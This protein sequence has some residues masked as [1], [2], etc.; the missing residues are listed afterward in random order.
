MENN[1]VKV[2]LSVIALL[3]VGVVAAVILRGE[4]V[5]EGP[6]KYDEFAQCLKDKG[7]VFY[8]AWWCPHCAD[9]KKLF[10]SSQKLLPYVECYNYPDT[11]N[12]LPICVDKK[13]EGYPTWDLADGTRLPNE[14]GAGVTL[15]TLAARTSCVLP[16]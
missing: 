13:I 9:Q 11:K 1:Q 2:F 10:G 12:P 8:G 6:G 5:P 15:E 4:S 16:E 3:V 7:A 14:N